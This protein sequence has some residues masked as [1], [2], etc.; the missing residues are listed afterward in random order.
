MGEK[1]KVFI[2]L[3]FMAPTCVRGGFSLEVNFFL[4][5][6]AT[7]NISAK[8]Y[9]FIRDVNVCFIFDQNSTD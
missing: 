1:L 5:N 9:A 6:Y 3:I 7:T 2:P 8:V 4:N